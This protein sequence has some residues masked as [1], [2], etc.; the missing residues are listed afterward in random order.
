MAARTKTQSTKNCIEPSEESRASA[1]KIAVHCTVVSW[2]ELVVR[3]H[4]KRI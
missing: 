4:F 1:I 3:Q 2:E